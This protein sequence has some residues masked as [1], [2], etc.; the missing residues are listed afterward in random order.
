MVPLFG[1]PERRQASDEASCQRSGDSV[2]ANSNRSPAS[3]F[4]HAQDAAQN[5]G[6][7]T[8]YGASHVGY[9]HQQFLSP[10]QQP[11]FHGYGS[12]P[13]SHISFAS[14]ASHPGMPP[15]GTPWSQALQSYVPFNASGP[16]MHPSSAHGMVPSYMYGTGFFSG[17]PSSSSGMSWG[18]SSVLRYR[19]T[20][21]SVHTM[22]GS[23]LR[24]R[25]VGGK[26]STVRY[27]DS[28]EGGG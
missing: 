23:P 16:T 14:A 17:A 21:D 11:Q 12:S 13:P 7:Q 18:L 2:V 25:V 6:Q 26:G 28:L 20:F 5:Q 15:L 10:M 3:H 1:V 22:I 24:S 27:R 8:V 4:F 9:N 19:V